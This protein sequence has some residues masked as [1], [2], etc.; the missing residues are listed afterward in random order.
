M[1]TALCL[2]A[3]DSGEPAAA[4]TRDAASQRQLAAQLQRKLDQHKL[5]NKPFTL[6]R[7][8]PAEPQGDASLLDAFA[9]EVRLC[10]STT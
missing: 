3:V 2:R 5:S 4:G 8:D 1:Q 6:C 10:I 7:M 9:A